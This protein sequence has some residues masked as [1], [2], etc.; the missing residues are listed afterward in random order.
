MALRVISGRPY[1][2]PNEIGNCNRKN[3]IDM[4]ASDIRTK[5]RTWIDCCAVFSSRLS[6]CGGYN[7]LTRLKRYLAVERGKRP[8]ISSWKQSSDRKYPDIAADFPLIEFAGRGAKKRAKTWSCL[9]QGPR[10]GA[11]IFRASTKKRLIQF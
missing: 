3:V 10:P 8:S 11:R 6:R 7:R 4:C 1:P 9:R 2:N 5:V